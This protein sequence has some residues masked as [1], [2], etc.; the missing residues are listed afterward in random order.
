MEDAVALKAHIEGGPT[1]FAAAQ[2]NLLVTTHSGK[3]VRVW[4]ID[5]REEWFVLPVDTGN[6]TSAAFSPD[7]RYVYY[8]VEGGVIRQ[9]PLDEE[10][11][12]DMARSRTFRDFN[13]D[14]CRRYLP[15]D[16]DCSVYREP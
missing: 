1:Q 14:E 2:G 7:G 16:T 5:T 6:F 10:E 13:S 15:K 4:R 9:M 8:E 12:V 11:L 3:E